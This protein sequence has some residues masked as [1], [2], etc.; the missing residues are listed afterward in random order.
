MLSINDVTTKLIL[1]FFHERVWLHSQL[2]T[3]GK[4]V[5]PS[6]DIDFFLCS[7]YS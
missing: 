3:S 7:L 2:V 5:L 1:Y 6:T 4:P